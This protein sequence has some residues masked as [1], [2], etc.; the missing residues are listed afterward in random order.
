MKKFNYFVGIIVITGL[1]YGLS[2]FIIE[3][4]EFAQGVKDDSKKTAHLYDQNTDSLIIIKTIPIGLSGVYEY[5]YENNTEDLIENHYLQFENGEAFYFGTSD[6]FDEAREGYYPGFFMSQIHNLKRDNNTI[7][8]QL[9]V[10]DSSFFKT[11]ITPMY[12]TNGNEPW[13]IAIRYET[14]DYKGELKGDTIVITTKDFD[15]RKFIRR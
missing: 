5:I 15:P 7:S 6:D 4:S 3:M 11:P 12:Q 10:N 14:R 1:I 9:N 2:S 8:F 13:G